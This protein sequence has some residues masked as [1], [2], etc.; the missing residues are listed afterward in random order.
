MGNTQ[1]GKPKAMSA[2]EAIMEAKLEA[3]R[4]AAAAAYKAA[5]KAAQEQRDP[6]YIKRI[7]ITLLLNKSGIPIAAF[8]SIGAAA[9]V[10]RT[11]HYRDL[12]AKQLGFAPEMRCQAYNGMGHD[13]WL[14]RSEL[15]LRNVIKVSA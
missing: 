4:R 13:Y 2:S 12:L 8:P 5:Y 7:Y 6:R 1:P 9:A 14:S 3:S 15:R 10:R 11:K